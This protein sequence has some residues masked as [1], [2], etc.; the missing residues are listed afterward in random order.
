L[1]PQEPQ[2]TRIISASRRTDLPGYHAEACADRLARLR[3]PFHSVFFWTRYPRP[4]FEGGRLAGLVRHGIEN[5]FVLLTLTG[6]GGS[7]LEPRVPPTREVLA[8]LDPLI[9]ALGGEPRRLI[10]RFDPVIRGRMT[11]ASFAALA[12][13]LAGRGVRT[14]IISFPAYMSLK[15][16]L[17]AQYRCFGV[18][19]WSRQEKRDFALRLAEVAACLGLEL[20]ACCQPKLVADA[21]GAITPAACI[22]AEL[23]AELHPR[24]LPLELGKDP[25]QRR[26]CRCAVSH[27]IGR[28]SDR[29]GSGCAYCY[30]SAGGPPDQG[31]PM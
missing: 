20:Q 9:A 25:R 4:L 19:R 22:S 7:E 30:S 5:P 24:G 26:H 23:A 1:A 13:E 17:D 21:G 27:D 14:C 11:V 2:V 29:C 31:G 18:E 12:P 16:P 6:L 3:R 10:W 28:Y 8:G 15:G